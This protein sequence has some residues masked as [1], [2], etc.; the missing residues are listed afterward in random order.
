[1]AKRASVRVKEKTKDSKSA[2]RKVDRLAKSYRE[3]QEALDEYQE[4]YEDILDGFEK[5]AIERNIA[6]D[7]LKR[8]CKDA[9]MSAGPLEIVVQKNRVFDG[10]Y[11]YDKLD[12]DIRDKIVEVQ[13]KVKPAIFDKFVQS[14]DI[15]P[16]MAKKSVAEM[17]EVIKALNS[18]P[19]I[20][21]G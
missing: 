14:G 8:G 21:M 6:L 10:K 19:E 18:P 5:L 2:K 17:K 3:A 13:Y 4:E 9:R 1:M 15:E 11:L 7:K 20:V 12:G 16:K